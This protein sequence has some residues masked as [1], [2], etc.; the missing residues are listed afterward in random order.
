MNND[1]L[2]AAK[3]LLRELADGNGNVYSEYTHFR[4]HL[5]KKKLNRI[6]KALFNEIQKAGQQCQTNNSK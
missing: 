5:G 1:L 6:V 3:M 4:S 2:N